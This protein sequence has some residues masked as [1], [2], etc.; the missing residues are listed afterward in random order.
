MS[1]LVDISRN[2]SNLLQQDGK[3][4]AFSGGQNGMARGLVHPTKLSFAPCLGIGRPFEKSGLVFRAT[5]GI[6]YRPVDMNTWCKQLHNVPIVF[7]F[8][9]QS[10]N[11]TPGINGFNFPQPVLG[12]TVTS[13]AAFDPYPPAQY[14]Q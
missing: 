9:Q 8:T 12:Q 5:Y 11:F 3:L 10:D 13:F 14:I 2:W 4:M 7:P 1:P 6:F